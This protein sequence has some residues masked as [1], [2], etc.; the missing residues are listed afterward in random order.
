MEIPAPAASITLSRNTKRGNRGDA[1]DEAQSEQGAAPRI[2]RQ[3]VSRACD[4]C[5]AGLSTNCDDAYLADLRRGREKC[6]GLRPVCQTCVQNDRNCTYATNP[7]KRGI[8]PGYIRTLEL[9]LAWLFAQ[10][11]GAEELLK[12]ELS[13]DGSH[14][15]RLLSGK[16]SPDSDD[17]HSQWASGIVCRQIDQLLS[18]AEVDHAYNDTA[19]DTDS[20]NLEGTQ[21]HHAG[22]SEQHDPSR[23]TVLANISDRRIV[24][25]SGAEHSIRSLGQDPLAQ[26][27]LPPTD[28]QA[29]L[30][31]QARIYQLPA[32]FWRLLDIYYAFSHSWLPISEKNDVLKTAYSYAPGGLTILSNEAGS[33]L[34]AE[35]WAILALASHQTSKSQDTELIV[36]SARSLIPSEDGPFELGHLRALLLLTLIYLGRRAWTA[37]WIFM[38]FA[39]RVMYDLNLHIAARMVGSEPNKSSS[40]AR[41]LV[42]ACFVLES[43]LCTY[44]N[45]SPHLTADNIASIGS[46]DE[47]GLEEWSPWESHGTSSSGVHALMLPRQPS[48]SMS[49]FN[50]LVDVLITRSLA[51]DDLHTRQT[52]NNQ[53]FRT[54][55]ATFTTGS[56][57]SSSLAAKES[58]AKLASTPQQMHVL[59]VSLWKALDQGVSSEDRFL[60]VTL[61][62][63]Q[64]YVSHCDILTVQPTLV[65]LLARLLQRTN[66]ESSVRRDLESLVT[67]LLEAWT[68]ASPASASKFATWV[69]GTRSTGSTQAAVAHKA[70]GPSVV[71]QSPLSSVSS[72]RPSHQISQ[73]DFLHSTPNMSNQEV[74]NL[75]MYSRNDPSASGQTPVNTRSPHMADHIRIPNGASITPQQDPSDL[76][77][78]ST[79]TTDYLQQP[80]YSM[81]PYAE[82]GSTADLEAIFEEIAMLDGTRQAND[83]TQF[84]QNLGVGPDLDLSAFFGAD[85]Q[86][87]DSVLAYFQQDALGLQMPNEQNGMFPGS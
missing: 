7:K 38:G 20:I 50:Q 37:S 69:P 21:A 19:G 64:H 65:P 55:G 3:R 13:I 42:L 56:L 77:Q 26:S 24:E 43:I 4:Q 16:N 5:R 61:Q 6:D 81:D 59:M 78:M 17:L 31:Q 14:V 73:Q 25:R 27:A 76:Y 60:D 30:L 34:H 36:A 52:P 71:T 8:Q 79:D 2:K 82:G 57:N 46:L 84:M 23:Q 54:N 66:L 29:S 85:Y 72:T 63:L 9:C 41:H 39:V 68:V 67:P 47:D 40:R 62:A 75:P 33:G 15:Q 44:L 70:V 28:V 74:A 22:G 1:T 86:Q 87:T 53:A 11:I 35:L 80:M 49:I 83:G 51:I 32:D 58:A 10:D 18:G 48:R 12:R 45:K